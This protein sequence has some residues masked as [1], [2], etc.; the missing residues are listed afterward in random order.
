MLIVTLVMLVISKLYRK[1]SANM[2]FVRTGMG[3]AKPIKDGGKIRG[4]A[5]VTATR[6]IDKRKGKLLYDKERTNKS[7]WEFYA[8]NTHPRAG[9]IELVSYNLKIQHYVE[10]G[11]GGARPKRPKNK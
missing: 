3:G 4:V 9:T 2:A 8:L 5:E 6:G 1:A 11:R 7:A 10:E